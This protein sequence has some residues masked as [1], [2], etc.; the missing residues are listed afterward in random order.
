MPPSP[1]GGGPF[2]QIGSVSAVP[3]GTTA[4]VSWSNLQ[5]ST[6]YEWFAEASDCQNTVATPT[7]TFTTAP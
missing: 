4:S 7:R 2:T 5:A 1:N 6:T 3:V